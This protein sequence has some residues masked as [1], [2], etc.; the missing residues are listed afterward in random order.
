MEGA[1]WTLWADL[2][3]AQARELLKW[4]GRWARVIAIRSKRPLSNIYREDNTKTARWLRLT[5]CVNILDE[6]PIQWQGRT[7]IPFTLKP[8]EELPYV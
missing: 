2:S 7:Y 6:H 8:L 3:K 1:I 4:A 5:R